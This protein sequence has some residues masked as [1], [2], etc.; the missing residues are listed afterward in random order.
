MFGRWHNKILIVEY[1]KQEDTLG[2]G[3][4]QTTPAIQPTL[5]H[6]TSYRPNPSDIHPTPPLTHANNTPPPQAITEARIMPDGRGCITSTPKS[7][8]F[9]SKSWFWAK[10]ERACCMPDPIFAERPYL[11][12]SVPV[13]QDPIL[14]L[15]CRDL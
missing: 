14:V 3:E 6:H 2:T 15:F 5:S 4:K 11:A 12:P 7:A 8:H 10:N 13:F 9:S 1:K